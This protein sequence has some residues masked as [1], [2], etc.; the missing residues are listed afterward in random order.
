MVGSK[1]TL[2]RVAS[3]GGSGGGS[4]TSGKKHGK[5]FGG[6][7]D[8]AKFSTNYNAPIGKAKKAGKLL[9]SANNAQNQG[10]K[11]EDINLKG[12][13]EAGRSGIAAAF[14]NLAESADSQLTS[15]LEQA[16]A[17]SGI[18]EGEI[19]GDLKKSDPGLNKN[20]STPPAP[21]EPEESIDQD[22]QFKQMIMKMAIQMVLGSVFGSMGSMMSAAMTIP[23]GA[24]TDAIGQNTDISK[25]PVN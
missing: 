16:A 9:A 4:G 24:E 10:K 12:K 2:S 19:G 17:D 7:N 6:G 20:D 18:A 13:E 11:A 1:G 14:N 25:P 23:Q 3:I 8:K 21:G 15:G 22:E 5:F